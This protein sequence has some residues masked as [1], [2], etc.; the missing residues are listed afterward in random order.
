MRGASTIGSRARSVALLALGALAVH[1]GRYLLTPASGD[2]GHG[3][4]EL[5]GP[6]IVLGTVAAIAVSFLAMLA[7]RC[8]PVPPAPEQ[9][10]DRAVLFAV[11]LLAVY[12]LQETGEALL[13]ADPHPFFSHLL[14]SGGWL[15]LPLAMAFGGLAAV[16]GSWLDRTE[17]RAAIALLATPLP[18][19]PRRTPRPAANRAWSPESLLGTL[20]L[21]PRAPPA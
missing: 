18:H 13:A 5:L 21:S 6:V 15:V 3:Y 7:L 2:H 12:F 8:L 9:A 1:Q 4:L 16:A 11:G 20:R 19:P 14:G 10:T 17:L